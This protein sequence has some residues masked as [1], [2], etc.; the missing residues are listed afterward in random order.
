MD[1]DLQ[2]ITQR[3]MQ[4]FYTLIMIIDI[5]SS[6]KNLKEIQEALQKV[7]DELNIK[8]YVQHEDIFRYM[9]RI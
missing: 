4:D 9:F 6:P 1:I 8:I 7:A 5:T 3:I 2:D